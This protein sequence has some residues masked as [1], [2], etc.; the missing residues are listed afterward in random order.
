MKKSLF[1]AIA[2]FAAVSGQIKAATV[3]ITN[4]T[5]QVIW[6]QLNDAQISRFSKNFD[7]RFEKTSKK[8]GPL[9]LAAAPFMAIEDA[10]NAPS[11]MVADFKRINPKQSRLLDSGLES[12]KKITFRVVD[13]KNKVK[14]VTIT[15][16]IGALVVE[17]KINFNGPNN[18]VRM[19]KPNLFAKPEP[20][21]LKTTVRDIKSM[22]K[23]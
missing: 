9:A 19:E 8:V 5:N 11:G 23:K 16:N 13:T 6:A 18:V 10:V 22:D 3:R 21:K 14:S 1:L 4:N 12:I 2:A 7:A 17:A 20:K 15:P